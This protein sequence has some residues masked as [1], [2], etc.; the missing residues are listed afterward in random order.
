MQVSLE[1]QAGLER[2]L[3]IQLPEHQIEQ[4]IT[5]RIQKLVREVKVDG[6]RPGKAPLRLVQQRYG[7]QARD[8][9]LGELVETSVQQAVREHQLRP[10][11]TP[12]IEPVA[13]TAG[14]GF[15]FVAVLEVYPDIAVPDV[16]TV[17]VQKPVATVTE[18]DVTAMIERLR[19]RQRQWHGV[20]R[21]AAMGDRLEVWMQEVVLDNDQHLPAADRE[22]IMGAPTA[23]PGVYDA[24]LGVVA[25]ETRQFTL[26]VPAEH[27]EPTLA[28]KAIHFEVRV[29]SVAEA[30]LP[31]VDAEFMRAFGIKEDNL[32]TF[33]TEVRLN[34]ERELAQA[35]RNRLKNQVMD[36]LVRL[37]SDFPLPQLLVDQD[38]AILAEETAAKATQM[39]PK[40]QFTASM[41]RPRAER[42]VRLG[43]LLGQIVAEHQIKVD[44]AR[45]HQ[46]VQTVAAGY[47]RPLEVMRWYYANPEKLKE[48]HSVVLEDQV[49]D[50]VVERAQVAEQPLGFF[51]LVEDK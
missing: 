23:M 9:A 35:K 4:A 22:I 45:L 48:L 21:G 25:G 51:E 8:E 17:Q 5:K 34:M 37:G 2:R 42:R 11:G 18:E 50:W 36:A 47:E 44:E 49:V 24:L 20:E 26:T 38:A 15:E 6:F 46:L 10:V 39:A 30:Y 7:A 32:D 33:R 29:K 43:L 41:F 12:R 27:P 28:G 14:V 19:L 1:A 16:S 13:R 3:T 40:M 31:E